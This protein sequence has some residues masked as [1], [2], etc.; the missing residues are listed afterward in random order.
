MLLCYL[1]KL[2]VFTESLHKVWIFVFT[3]PA[4]VCRVLLRCCCAPLRAEIT[5][6]WQLFVK[7]AAVQSRLVSLPAASSGGVAINTTPSPL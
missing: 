2:R 4:V 7:A 6:N 3:Y 1:E 5:H